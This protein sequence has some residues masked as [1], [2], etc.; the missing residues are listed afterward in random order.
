MS[1]LNTKFVSH[2]A[3]QWQSTGTV[4]NFIFYGSQIF[5]LL[6]SMY[7]PFTMLF[8]NYCNK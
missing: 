7:T 1:E 3:V 5:W 4:I 8:I 6:E 2:N